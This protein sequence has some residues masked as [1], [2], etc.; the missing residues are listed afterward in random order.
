[1]THFQLAFTPS[2]VSFSITGNMRNLS[3]ILLLLLVTT[4]ASSSPSSDDRQA[5]IDAV[6]SGAAEPRRDGTF[7]DGPFPIKDIP[8]AVL[9]PCLDR[10]GK[11]AGAG[12]SWQDSC[13]GIG[14]VPVPHAR[15]DVACRM[16]D[17]LWQLTCE[18]GGRGHS[19]SLLKIHKSSAGWTVLSKTLVDDPWIRCTAKP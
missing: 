1:M 5:Y 13:V 12:E 18:R 2:S 10:D 16:T 14:D 4:G 7:P 19:M 9:K 15:L 3:L 6:M 8:K 11:I 17:T